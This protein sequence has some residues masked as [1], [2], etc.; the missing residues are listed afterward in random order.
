M[1]LWSLWDL[2]I[3]ASVDT[4]AHTGEVEDSLTIACVPTMYRVSSH[5]PSSC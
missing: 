3:K 2:D 1:N 5:W 4:L